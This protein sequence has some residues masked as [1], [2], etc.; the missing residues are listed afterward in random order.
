M[1]CFYELRREFCFIDLFQLPEY[2][3]L[4]FFAF[5][6]LML[7]PAH[8]GVLTKIDNYKI[9]ENNDT[10]ANTLRFEFYCFYWCKRSIW[11]TLLG[12]SLRVL[13]YSLDGNFIQEL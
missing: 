8:V 5:A 2:S 4:C 11:S 3:C 7:L 10:V 9:K 12:S 6:S 1:L 13:R